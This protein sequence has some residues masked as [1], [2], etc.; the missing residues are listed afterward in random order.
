[1]NP[2]RFN[3]NNEETRVRDSICQLANVVKIQ[4]VNQYE[5]LS[6]HATVTCPTCQG[7]REGTNPRVEIWEPACST[8]P[9]VVNNEALGYFR[10]LRSY[11]PLNKNI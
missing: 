3:H 9:Q 8:K 6:P 2:F 7:D 11:Y 1:M 10:Y 5:A 4:V